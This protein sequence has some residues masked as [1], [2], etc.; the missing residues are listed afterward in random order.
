LRWA[1]YPFLAG[2]DYWSFINRVRRDWNVN[3]TL[4]GPFA[5]G[6]PGAIDM[7]NARLRDYLE[8]KNLK[9]VA[10]GPWLDY[11]CFDTK[12]NRLINRQE[13]R[14]ML[15]ETRDKLKS[16][17]PEIQVLGCMEG[18]FV[19]VPV[20]D[21]RA[22]YDVLPEDQRGAT[23]PKSMTDDQIGLLS[24]MTV[25]RLLDS[26][27][28]GEDGK[29]C[30]ELY[31]RG[32]Q[33]TPLIALLVYPSSTNTHREIWLDQARFLMEDVGLDG[34]YL[35]GGGPVSGGRYTFETWDGLTVDIDSKTGRILRKYTDHQLQIVEGPCRDLFEYVLSK[36]GQVVANGYNATQAV[37]QLPIVRFMET[38]S[39]YN[40][41]EYL[42]EK[43]PRVSGMS[44]GHLGPPVALANPPY[45]HD[46]KVDAEVKDN[47]AQ[48]VMKSVVTNLRHGL[49]Y[50][51][52]GVEV[53]SSG[54]GSGDYGPM[55]FMYPIT[56]VEL[57]EGWVL[58]RERIVSAR[59]LDIV[60]RKQGKP[61]LMVFNLHGRPISP[62]KRCSINAASTPDTWRI[63]LNIDDWNQIA[64]VF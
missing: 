4:E 16:V 27:V 29:P 22:L 12:R 35:D 60:W 62:E 53:P 26:V 54:T 42:D 38:G 31:Y 32:S 23:Y 63:Q 15:R 36:N 51:Y 52:Y 45:S 58:G 56:P 6:V 47:Y 17:D 30:Y 41:L 44:G 46:A 40:P 14:Q 1:C 5:F 11:D 59:S 34:I 18:P 7:D 61:Q 57:H 37:Q 21:S 50:Y 24:Q 20:E 64:V 33:R 9:L 13:A 39:S 8:R 28:R 3:R 49:L 19:S 25:G 48:F 10:I 2:K 55:N 43:P